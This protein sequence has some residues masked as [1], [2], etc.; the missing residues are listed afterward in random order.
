[1]IDPFIEKLVSDL[2]PKKPLA[3]RMLWMHCTGCLVMIAALIL[4]LIGLRGDYINAMQTGAMFWKPSYY[5][6]L[7]G[8][9]AFSAEQRTKELGIRKVLGAKVFQIVVNFSSEFA[10]LILVSSLIACPLA[11][12]LVRSWLSDFEYQTPIDLWYLY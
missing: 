2:K 10:K 12:F 4:G 6:F 8:L 5:F 9:A 3:N 11:Y 7:F 1:M